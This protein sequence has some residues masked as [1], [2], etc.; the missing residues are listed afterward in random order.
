VGSIRWPV[1]VDETR[2]EKDAA[3]GKVSVLMV[4]FFWVVS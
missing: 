2:E 4:G 3:D 1:V